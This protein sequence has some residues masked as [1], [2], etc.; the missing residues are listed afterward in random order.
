VP[1]AWSLLDKGK[2][3]DQNR[4]GFE[5]IGELMSKTCPCP[6]CRGQLRQSSGGVN[7]ALALFGDIPF[8]IVFGLCLALGM[9]RWLAGVLAFVATISVFYFYDRSKRSYVCEQCGKQFDYAQA[10]A[11]PA[12]PG[13]GG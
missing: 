6:A 2:H 12:V 3:L 11:A 10:H 13:I 9:W 4:L 1:Q 5:L 7:F 8:W